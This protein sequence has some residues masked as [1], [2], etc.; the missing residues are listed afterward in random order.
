MPKLYPVQEIGSLAKPRWRTKG[1]TQPLSSKD[2]V[3]AG[4]W[5]ERLGIPDFQDR[6]K[7]L[8]AEQEQ[9]DRGRELLALSTIYGLRLFQQTGLANAGV[10]GEQQR[11]DMYGPVIRAA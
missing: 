8:L 2:L 4:E 10:A 5:A 7:Q 11:V 9:N 3:E 1:L 6:A